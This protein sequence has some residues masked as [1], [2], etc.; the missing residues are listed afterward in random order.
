MLTAQEYR[1]LLVLMEHKNQTLTRAQLLE[2]LWDTDGRF[3]SDNT[4]TVTMRR[5]R[6]KLGYPDC[7]QTLRGIGYRMEG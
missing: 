2:R 7:I 4:L 5:L 3:V 1:L 6:E